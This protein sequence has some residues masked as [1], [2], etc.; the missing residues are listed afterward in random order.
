MNS[1]YVHRGNWLRVVISLILAGLAL[2][3]GWWL[4]TTPTTAQDGQPPSSLE[5]IEE[6]YLR[7]ELAYE[8]ALV[9][10]VYSVFAPDRLPPQFRSDTPS[11]GATLVLA[12]VMHAWDSLS[13]ETKTLLREF[14]LGF[15]L[16]GEVVPLE[17]TRPTLTNEEIHDTAHFLIHYTR[18]GT[19]AVYHLSEDV[20]PANGV[21]DYVDWVAED[22]EYVWSTE[23]S[24]MGWLQPPPD[25]GEGGDTHYDV[26]LKNCPPYYGYVN[27]TDGFVGDNPNSPTVSETNAYYSYMVLENDFAAFPG[28]RRENIRVT[29]AHEFNHA[30]QVGYD[31]TE[32]IEATW[33]MEATA[34]WMED[35]VYDEINDNYQFLDK[36]FSTP[37]LALDT[38]HSAYTYSRWIFMRYVSEHYGANTVRRIWE[39]TVVQNGMNAVEAALL[40]AGTSFSA[41]FPRF[42]AANYVLSDLPPNAPYDYEEADGY[43]GA[44]GG[45][46]I[47]TEAVITF[48]GTPLTYNSFDDQEED[49]L[50]RRSAEYIEVRS[51]INYQVTFQSHDSTDFVVQG[52][53]RHPDGRVTI[54]QV[55]LRGG[56]GTWAVTDPATY[57]EVV[58]IV[59]NR[60]DTDEAT[61]YDLT[62]QTTSET[63]PTASLIA[64][65]IS[66]TVDTVFNFDAS[67]STDAQTPPAQLEVR[68]DWDGD[69]VWDTDWSTTKTATH[70]YDQPGTYP[71]A[72]EVRDGVDLRDTATYTITVINTRP[73]A[74]FSVLPTVGTTGTVFQFD[75]SASSDYETPSANLEVRWDWENDGGW[76]TGYS[77]VKQITHSYG[78]SNT[79]TIVLEVRDG[80]SLTDTTAHT[81][82]V[83]AAG[84]PPTATF[85][86]SPSEGYTNTVF[87]FDAS[88]CDDD[89]T[90]PTELQ[91]RWDWENDGGFDTE[92]STTKVI[93]HTFDTADIYTVALLV[94]DEDGLESG[95]THT[96][97]VNEEEPGPGDFFVYLPVALKSYL[98]N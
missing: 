74:A 54:K 66:G 71:V 40:E 14:G 64:S 58:V 55:T 7:G 23:I 96:V 13:L 94:R 26:Y 87:S 25:A 53:L 36:L 4:L 21:P 29:A 75:A 79:Y 51:A 47:G 98:P 49:R 27:Y 42:T 72:V 5:L 44:I 39:H 17:Q 65:P 38:E 68:W 35:E 15:P 52:A 43:K 20:D 2:L 32:A 41:V 82:T 97:R 6:A 69:W 30:I 18:T 67:G 91:V 62:F 70:S 78:L 76:D 37:D 84:N 46:A 16:P 63:P 33:L 89:T 88:G 83:R 11:R 50:E 86:V 57:D 22:L 61:G 19:D 92:W 9:Y 56:Q 34:T 31:G 45:G 8:T 12:E 3:G 93:T 24:S 77:T 48:T 28:D 73:V 81:V 80:Q 1:K 85:T 59:T 90:P 10:K 95:I 60:G